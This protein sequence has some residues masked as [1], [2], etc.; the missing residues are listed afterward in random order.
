MNWFFLLCNVTLINIILSG[1]NAL[2]ISIAAG[3][4]PRKLRKKAILFGSIVAILLL[5]LFITVGSYVIKLPVLKSIA[6]IL[7]MWIAAKLA[8]DRMKP[9][10]NEKPENEAQSEGLLKAIGTIVIADLGMELDNAMAMLGAANGRM[11][12]LLV[13]LLITIPFLVVGSHF[14]ANLMD[15]FSWITYIASTYIAWIAGNMFAD[16]PVFQNIP[17]SPLLQWMAPVLCVLIFI[18]IMSVSLIRSRHRHQTT[19]QS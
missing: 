12:V 6:G 9:A 4:L 17:W 13:G 10:Q 8:V 2:A 3:R 19:R 7:L 18:T 5:I 11:S 16:D 14:I 15:K 1:D